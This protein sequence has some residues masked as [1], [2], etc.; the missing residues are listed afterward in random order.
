MRS[1]KGGGGAGWEA[2]GGRAGAGVGAEWERG[3]WQSEGA[4]AIGVVAVC[5]ARAQAP[6]PAP[7]LHSPH[8]SSTAR[9]GTAHISPARSQAPQ[10][11]PKLPSPHANRPTRTQTAQP[12]PNFLSPARN[13][14]TT[15][16]NPCDSSQPPKNPPH[17]RVEHVLSFESSTPFSSGK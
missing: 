3:W 10:P 6:Q 9:T 16:R 7:K 14:S 4:E 8:P 12:A 5:P 17:P 13:S 11:A 15:T 2:G 1:S